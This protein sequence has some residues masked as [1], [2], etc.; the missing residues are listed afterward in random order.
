MTG[1]YIIFSEKINK[2]YIGATQEDVTTRIEK[3]NNGS[4]GK[5]R[6]TATDTDWKLMLFI[7]VYYTTKKAVS[8]ETAFRYF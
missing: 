3:H 1:C 4:Y 7:S 6:F 2:F 5:N 8:N